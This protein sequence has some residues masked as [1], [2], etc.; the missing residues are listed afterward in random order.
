MFVTLRRGETRQTFNIWVYGDEHLARGSGL[1]VGETGVACNHH[2]LLP[3]NGTKFQFLAGE[4]QI[5]VF[6][7]LVGLSRTH[8]LS[9]MNLVIPEQ[10]AVQ[11]QD[12]ECGIYFDWG[13]DSNRYH[14]HV[15]KK[16]FPRAPNF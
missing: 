12:P 3:D 10:A 6:A 2:F 15:E 5:D 14:P 8:H 16:K 1:F 11:L 4:Y 9:K 7:T 13:P